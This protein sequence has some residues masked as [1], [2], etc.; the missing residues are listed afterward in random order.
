MNMAWLL[1]LHEFLRT[2]IAQDRNK[3]VK[4]DHSTLTIVFMHLDSLRQLRWLGIP[5]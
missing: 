2:T 3:V 5:D 1:K 4:N